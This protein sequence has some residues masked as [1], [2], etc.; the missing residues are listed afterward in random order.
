MARETASNLRVARNQRVEALHHNGL[1]G[2]AESLTFQRGRLK[3]RQDSDG[4][5]ARMDAV[6]KLNVSHA[7]KSV[8]DEDGDKT[9]LRVV[10]PS[11]VNGV[12]P[13]INGTPIDI[14]DKDGEL[15][16]FEITKSA[17]AKRGIAERAHVYLRYDLR[18]EDFTVERV[19]FLA[20]ATPLG[21]KPFQFHKLFGWLTRQDG[22][23]KWH[24]QLF[25]PA[26]FDASSTDE[27]RGTFRAWPRV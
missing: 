8:I 2:L 14:A 11:H 24:P 26:Y 5:T 1:V 13:E 6:A 3:G 10:V 17:W 9:F 25:F 22:S 21:N 18:K 27:N 23:V 7:W 4:F 19:T 20:S 16:R 15:P 12:V